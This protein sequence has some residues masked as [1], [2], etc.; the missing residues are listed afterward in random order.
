MKINRSKNKKKHLT[1]VLM[2]ILVIAI[3]GV[4]YSYFEKVWL[5]TPSTE[6]QTP[7]PQKDTSVPIISNEPQ[8]KDSGI[9]NKENLANSEK[10]TPSLSHS[11]TGQ[12]KAPVIDIDISREKSN[13]VTISTKI[14][15]ISNGVC[16]LSVINK[17]SNILKT[18]DIIYQ[19]EFSTCAGFDIK[20]A[21]LGNGTWKIK[22]ELI[23]NK[24]TYVKESSFDVH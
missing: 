4:A 3:S 15:H 18:A 9:K 13:I 22:L 10:N 5:F 20:H 11:R 14:Q 17:K 6:N 21:E 7:Q 16:K 23:S 12:S 2:L 8:M 19:P 1:T 24:K